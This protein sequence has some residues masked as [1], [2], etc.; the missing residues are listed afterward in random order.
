MAQRLQQRLLHRVLGQLQQRRTEDARQH[1]HQLRRLP[2]KQ[3]LDELRHVGGVA[4]AGVGDVLLICTFLVASDLASMRGG[5]YRYVSLR[6][7]D[8]RAHFHETAFAQDRTLFGDLERGV[9]VG[10][11][12]VVAPMFSSVSAYG[13]SI[14]TRPA[15]VHT[16][17]P[18][19]A[20]SSAASSW[21]ARRSLADQSMY[22]CAMACIC[23]GVNV[24]DASSPPR[25]NNMNCAIWTCLS[26]STRTPP[27]RAV[28]TTDERRCR[29]TTRR[30]APGATATA[31]APAARPARG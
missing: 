29:K 19:P 24:L 22:G 11:D 27:D 9:F 30:S 4:E 17:R 25:N 26:M 20:S 10:L 16:T 13:P 2:P 6:M 15:I 28:H 3:V 8:D 12:G 5:P 21:P 23:S 31:T 1:R 7:V 18:P 14:D